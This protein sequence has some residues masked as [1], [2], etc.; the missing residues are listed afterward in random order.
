M[1]IKDLEPGSSEQAPHQYVR[2]SPATAVWA[3]AAGMVIVDDPHAPTPPGARERVR[4]WFRKVFKRPE[5]T[6]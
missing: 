2:V 4:Y 5:N 6:G 1:A 3:K